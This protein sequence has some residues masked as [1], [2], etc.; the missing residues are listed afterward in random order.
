MFNTNSE[1]L[2]KI[3]YLANNNLSILAHHCNKYSTL[4]Q[5]VDNKKNYEGGEYGALWKIC[6]IQ[7]FCKPKTVLTHKTY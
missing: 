3:W 5:D 7:F 2:H 4:M 6:T 1:P